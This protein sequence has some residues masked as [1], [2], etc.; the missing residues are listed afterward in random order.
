MASWDS[1][2]AQ[3]PYGQIVIAVRE[4]QAADRQPTDAMAGGSR[5]VRA[6]MPVVDRLE[7]ELRGTGVVIVLADERGRVIARRRTHEASVEAA[8]GLWV[9]FDEQTQASAPIVD[10]GTGQRLGVLSLG[11][12]V[13]SAAPLLDVLVRHG[14]R[15]IEQ[16]L[17][18]A[19]TV[20]DRWLNEAFL[21]ARRRA[22][23][24]FL[25]VNEDVLMCN[26]RAAR[27]FDQR[28]RPS[29]WAAAKRCGNPVDAPGVQL[30][31]RSGASVLATVTPL[32]GDDG[33]IAAALVH[34]GPH[35]LTSRR[36]R[37]HAIGWQG[38]TDTERAIA[39]LV[40][41]GLTNREVAARVFLSH[42]TVDSH[43]RKVFQKLDVHS[44]VA[45]AAIVA[46]S[47]AQLI[48][49]GFDGAS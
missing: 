11:W 32:R 40:A 28:D 19:R 22:R 48:G 26:A 17:L 30:A 29:L 37:P 8:R 23:G 15:G 20:R 12:R 4:A 47:S 18:D 21:R 31:T 34:I 36:D 25:L 9:M 3:S 7:R 44:R 16:E 10:Q 24:P 39:G 6:A 49:D 41:Q 2:R 27:L 45:L 38:L 13:D 42:H 43:L 35:N 14:A 1:I 33:G 46:G 5:L